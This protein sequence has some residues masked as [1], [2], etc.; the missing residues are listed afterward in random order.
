MDFY[1]PNL[2]NTLCLWLMI[3]SPLGGYASSQE[4]S[5]KLRSSY[6]EAIEK[7]QS[8]SAQ[9]KKRLMQRGASYLERMAK[10]LKESGNMGFFIEAHKFS[11]QLDKG[12]FGTVSPEQFNNPD[13]R[14]FHRKLTES[15]AKID[16]KEKHQVMRVKSVMIQQLESMVTSLNRSGETDLA[17][18]AQDELNGLKQ[19]P[20]LLAYKAKLEAHQAAQREAA[21]RRR[22]Y[23]ASIPTPSGPVVPDMP[24]MLE[25]DISRKSL[26]RNDGTD[27]DNKQQNIQL[28]VDIQSRELVKDYGRLTVNVYG[29]AQDV[30][31]SSNYKILLKETFTIDQLERGKSVELE[32]K[33]VRNQY[34]NN[35]YAQFGFKFYGYACRIIEQASG[36]VVY[37]KASPSRLSK[38]KDDI[39]GKVEEEAFT[40]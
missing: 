5:M 39:F 18:L 14:E 31:S 37:E 22:R 6:R 13:V 40:M 21:A 29:I 10:D 7:A 9:Q 15:L 32:T 23:V 1:K 8:D 28:K 26:S 35:D 24:P 36:E 3:L 11:M 12:L 25:V 34:D 30:L 4:Q 38:V 33:V 27:Y 19:D 16:A 2:F 20:E 17:A